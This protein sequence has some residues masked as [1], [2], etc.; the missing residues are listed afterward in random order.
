MYVVHVLYDLNTSHNIIRY[1]GHNCLNIT[2]RNIFFEVLEFPKEF[3]TI[4]NVCNAKNMNNN[5]KSISI[6][7]RLQVT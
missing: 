6:A 1:R 3:S 5:C 4:E 2:T 7:P